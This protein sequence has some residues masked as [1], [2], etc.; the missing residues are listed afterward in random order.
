[1]P[2][3]NDYAPL[4]ADAARSPTLPGYFYYAPDIYER[5]KSLIFD[6][7]WQLVAHESEMENAGDYVASE[8]AEEKV[9]V[10]RG[11]DGVLRAFYNICQHR[12]HT[13]LE[14]TGNIRNVIM[15]PY[16]AWTYSIRGELKTARHTDN[17]PDFDMADYSL[18]EIRLE[19]ACGFV[20]INLDPDA[21]TI[22]ETWPGFIDSLNEHVPWWNE[23]GFHS[24]SD[25]MEGSPLDANWKV[26]AENCRECYHC[27]P[28][29]PAFVGLVNM[30]TYEHNYRDGW[31]LNVAPVKHHRN[32]AYN[33]DPDEP[34]QHALFWHLWPNSLI[35]VSPG[36]KN[37][38][39][40]RYY[41]SGP[42][43]TRM[44]SAFLAVPG[45]GIK[46]ERIDYVANTLWPED[47]G[48][49]EAVHQGLKSK[50]YRQGRFVVDGDTGED[51]ER[52]IHEFQL[53]YA[54]VMGFDV[55]V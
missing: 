50:G 37:M 20:F 46:Q 9:F 27:G 11:D 22:E 12:A 51:T 4:K 33:V 42:E 23:L 7:T 35:G 31:L 47:E 24:R 5:E 43:K 25:S 44:Q 49:C 2:V 19:T 36:E 21:P 16:H 48:I 6:R 8:I 13:L 40:F 18:P 39:L 52:P 28:A 10:I 38:N 55:Q 1:M 34:C 41:P 15:C 26:L 30:K 29:H 45:V 17:Q 53:Q 32:D 3:R 14:G 54:S